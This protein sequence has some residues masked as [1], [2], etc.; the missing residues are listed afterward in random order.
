VTGGASVDGAGVGGGASAGL[1]AGRGAF[2]RFTVFSEFFL[3]FFF[4][5]LGKILPHPPY[6]YEL[7]VRL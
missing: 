2:F 6:A 4:A 3:P 5:F 1:R 7:Q